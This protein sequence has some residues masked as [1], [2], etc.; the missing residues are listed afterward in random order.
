MHWIRSRYGSHDELYDAPYFAGVDKHAQRSARAMAQSIV[1]DFAPARVVDVGCGTGALLAELQ[2]LGVEVGGL[3]YAEAALDCCRGRGVNVTRVDLEGVVGTDV[4]GRCDVAVS[5][6]VAEHLPGRVAG[7]LV[8]LL[9]RAERA[10]VFGAAR[11]GQGGTDH[12]NEQPL[13]YWTAR[14]EQN[15]FAC[16]EERTARWRQSWIER[17]VSW[18]YCQNLLVFVRVDRPVEATLTSGA[19]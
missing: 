19:W 5:Q 12:V 8:E 11:P 3:E 18:Y 10:V 4:I 7:Q 15:G 6:E 1:A 17:D 13:E 16:D 14:F 9:C 2:S